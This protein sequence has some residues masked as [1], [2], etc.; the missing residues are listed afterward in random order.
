MSLILVVIFCPSL[1]EPDNGTLDCSI[2]D[3]GIAFP[4]DTCSYTCDDGFV[5]EGSVTVV[6]GDDGVWSDK[7]K[8]VPRGMHINK[9]VV[10]CALSITEWRY[11]PCIYAKQ[12]QSI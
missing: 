7:T 5:L 2:G 3:H 4:N 1:D 8:C 12:C 10:Y 6:C 9:C 11:S